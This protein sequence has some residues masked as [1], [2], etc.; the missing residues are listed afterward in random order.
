MVAP[1]DAALDGHTSHEQRRL[2]FALRPRH[3]EASGCFADLEKVRKS[4]SANA[5]DEK[6]LQLYATGKGIRRAM[7]LKIIALVVPQEAL[8]SRSLQESDNPQVRYSRENIAN[9]E[10]LFHRLNAGGTRLEGD[11]LVYSMI[12][13]YWPDV[14]EPI[15]RLAARRMPESRLVMLGARA[16]LADLSPP[17][18]KSVAKALPGA[19]SV[20]E[21][22]RIALDTASKDRHR[23][24]RAFF[25]SDGQ[26]ETELESVLNLISSWLGDEDNDGIGLPKVLHTSIARNSPDV[27][28]VLMWLARRA[29]AEPGHVSRWGHQPLRE[30]TLGLA[31]VL[32]WF[33][34]DKARAVE[35][36]AD[37]L[38]TQPLTSHSFRGILA[39]AYDLGEGHVGLHHPMTPEQLDRTIVLPNDAGGL[40]D[41]QWWNLVKGDDKKEKEVWPFLYRVKDETELLVYAQRAFIKARFESYDPARQ[42]MWEQHDRPWDYDHILPSAWVSYQRVYSAVREWAY[43]LANLRAW[44]MAENRSDQKESPV[45][46]IA[47]SSSGVADSFLL[48]EELNG[49]EKGYQYASSRSSSEDAVAFL[50]AAKAR[51]Q[52]IYGE[53]Y[54][55]LRIGLFDR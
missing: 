38:R 42:D 30:T 48:E 34:K 49:F 10:H 53:W 50:Q 40:N 45:K 46:K 41:W 8:T 23:R 24:I 51:L 20:S 31:T 32:H 18:D 9:V 11:D 36:I 33:G 47:P 1:V 5:D 13:A 28:L 44:P 43:S 54:D 55:K 15:R 22:R 26:K 2:T 19:L 16:A 25:L 35:H 6:R 17:T 29:L 4:T 7:E 21:L 12:K 3:R 52:R 37:K 14:E 27:Y 39:T